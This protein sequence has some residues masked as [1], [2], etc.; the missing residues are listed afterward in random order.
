MPAVRNRL[1]NKKLPGPFADLVQLMP[2][3]AIVDDVHYENTLEMIDRLMA[4]GKLTKGQSDYLETLVQLVQAYETS[5]HAIDTSEIGGISVLEHLLDESDMNATD[6]AKVLG[7]HSSMGSKL[8]KGE[9]SLTIEHI[10]KL[11]A[12]FSVNPA[13]F[14][15]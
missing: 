8:L 1:K 9:R 11:A 4:S 12:R 13:V 14:I 5:H 10:K 7:V 2:P 3:Q 6:L 15:D